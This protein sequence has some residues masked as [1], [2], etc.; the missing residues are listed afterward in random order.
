MQGFPFV[1]LFDVVTLRVDVTPDIA[2]LNEMWRVFRFSYFLPLRL[3]RS[4]TLILLKRNKEFC[5]DLEEIN[6]D[7][8]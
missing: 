4:S 3:E 7:L 8:G 2:V 1:R 5:T 6:I